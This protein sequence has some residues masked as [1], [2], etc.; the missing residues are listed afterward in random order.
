M[1][2]GDPLS[3][4]LFCPTKEPLSRG[5]TLLYSIEQNS[6]I[7]AL[8]GCRPP[9]HVLYVNDLF[10]IFAVEM[11]DLVVLFGISQISMVVLLDINAN[12]STFYLG[13]TSS[14]SKPQVERYLSFRLGMAPFTYLGD[15]IFK[16]RR[17]QF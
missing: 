15:P 9:T 13:S 3:S 14:H 4:L 11:F 2:Q 6:S 17:V 7:P 5:L 10:Y 12:K 16:P 8:R 1:C